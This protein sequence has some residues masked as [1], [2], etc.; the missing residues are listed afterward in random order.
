MQTGQ[1]RYDSAPPAQYFVAVMSAGRGYQAPVEARLQH[2]FGPILKRSQPYCFSDFSDYYEKE[3]GGRVWKYFLALAALRGADQLVAVKQITEAIEK[4]F[5]VEDKSASDRAH[6]L[7]GFSRR[8]NLDPGYLTG[9]NLVLSTV[10]NQAQRIYLASGIYAEVT[11]IFRA[12][13]F[14]PLPWTFPDYKS[15][16]VIEFF[17]DLRA[18]YQ[19]QLRRAA[20]PAPSQSGEAP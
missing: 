15:P 12:G 4:E 20:L 11:L 5:A 10:K 18:S 14:R 16:Q 3:I 2:H 6:A 7:P 13:R 19:E 9:W 17:G 1:S 8:V